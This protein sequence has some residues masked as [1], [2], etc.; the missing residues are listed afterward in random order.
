MS[1]LL[2]RLRFAIPGGSGLPRARFLAMPGGSGLKP[3]AP[4]ST[5]SAR[6]AAIVI[7]ALIRSA[8]E[9]LNELLIQSWVLAA[10]PLFASVGVALR[11][12]LAKDL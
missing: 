5:A 2:G 12:V 4:T 3:T 9:L 6:A 8:V 10:F 1:K 11:G 7:P